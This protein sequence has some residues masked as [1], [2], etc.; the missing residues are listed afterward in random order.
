MPSTDDLVSLHP[1]PQPKY[2]FPGDEDRRV[3]FT[4]NPGSLTLQGSRQDYNIDLIN[5][6]LLYYI[7]ENKSGRAGGEVLMDNL[8][9]YFKQPFLLTNANEQPFD[10]TNL[11]GLFNKGHFGDIIVTS[12]ER[13]P[14]Y[15]R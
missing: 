5:S 6:D 2:S 14:P 4:S 15:A 10:E 7:D 12:S 11:P 9:A 3:H 13:S 1:I 8:D